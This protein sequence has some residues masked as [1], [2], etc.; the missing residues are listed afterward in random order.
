MMLSDLHQTETK[1]LCQVEGLELVITLYACSAD[2]I[3]DVAERAEPEC[4]ILYL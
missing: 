1:R 2:L 4:G 3:P